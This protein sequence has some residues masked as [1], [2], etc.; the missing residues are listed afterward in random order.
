MI[1]SKPAPLSEAQ[2]E[3]LEKFARFKLSLEE[4]RRCLKGL[5]EFDFDAEGGTRWME[6]HFE[7][8][9]PGV[10]ITK[11]HVEDALQKRRNGLIAEQELV[12]WATMILHNNAYELDEKDED[13][14]AQWL[15]DISFDLHP[16]PE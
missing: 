5:V 13:L 1:P 6:T 10:L 12:E 16:F 7:I 11:R 4:L 3:C 8:P 15:N 2:I 9:V 14:I